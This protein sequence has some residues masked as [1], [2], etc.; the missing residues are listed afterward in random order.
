MFGYC[1][2]GMDSRDPR[3][4]V[5]R[6][7]IHAVCEGIDNDA[8]YFERSTFAGRLLLS[9]AMGLAFNKVR[10]AGTWLAA[11]PSLPPGT[12]KPWLRLETKRCSPWC[13]LLA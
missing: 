6:T 13:G 9:A 8:F 7:R 10:K 3:D 1:R 4:V 2:R 5:G 12:C 11:L